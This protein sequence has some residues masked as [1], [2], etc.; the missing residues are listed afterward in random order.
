MLHAANV[1]I[2]ANVAAQY[3]C[4]GFGFLTS[5]AAGAVMLATGWVTLAYSTRA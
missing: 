4:A 5:L 3:S 1:F 2:A